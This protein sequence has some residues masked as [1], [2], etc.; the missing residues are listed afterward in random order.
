MSAALTVTCRACTVVCAW[1]A[2]VSRSTCDEIPL[3]KAASTG[4]A[5]AIETILQGMPGVNPDTLVDDAGRTPLFHAA[6]NGKSVTAITMLLDAGSDPNGA[7]T[8]TSM[9]TP[10]HGA[11]LGGLVDAV[12]VLLR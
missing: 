5:A 3:C 7:R 11:T 9:P 6:F 12:E 8:D 2:L 4:D 10:L 1:V